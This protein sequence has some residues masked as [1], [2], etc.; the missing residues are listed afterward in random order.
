MIFF[1]RSV[2]FSVMLLVVSVDLGE[3]GGGRRVNKGSNLRVKVKLTLQEIAA[4]TEKKIKVN[5]YRYL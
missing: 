4:G 3:A 5:K 2:I 1:H